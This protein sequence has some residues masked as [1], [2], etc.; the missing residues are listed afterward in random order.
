MSTTVPAVVDRPPSPPSWPA[1]LRG[2][3]LRLLGVWALTLLAVAGLGLL[4]TRVLDGTWPLTAEDGVN[5]W[6]AERRTPGWTVLSTV[7]S[8]FGNTSTVIVVGLLLVVVLHRVL[9]RWRESL[10][11]AGC[12]LGQFLAFL[13]SSRIVGRS[14]PEVEQI[15]HSIPTSSFPSGHTSA[16]LALYG[17]LAVVVART[18]RPAWL[19]RSLLTLLLL[20]PVLVGTGRLYRGMHHPSDLVGALLNSGLVVTLTTLVVLRAALPEGPAA[21]PV[22]AADPHDSPA[23]HEKETVA[24]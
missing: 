15:D 24:P 11:V 8:G 17:G 9:R 3:F 10:L 7:G 2:L 21:A 13:G 1:A 5:R 18:V 20:L 16:S 19:R 4:L 23:P 6:F 14:R 12:V 22:T